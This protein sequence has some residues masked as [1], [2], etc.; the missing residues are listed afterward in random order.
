MSK[1]SKHALRNSLSETCD[2]FCLRSWQWHS[3]S[4]HYPPLMEHHC[5]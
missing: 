4:R 5:S 2:L 1:I 3:S